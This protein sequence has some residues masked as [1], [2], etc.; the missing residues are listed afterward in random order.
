M[1]EWGVVGVLIALLG[2]LATVVNPIITLTRSITKLT[3]VVE[4]L[5]QD[6]ETQRTSN[7]KLW[8]HNDEQDARI[9]DHETRICLLEEKGGD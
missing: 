2:L 3:V 6:M 7:G 4:R 8:A 9:S 1:T 5:S